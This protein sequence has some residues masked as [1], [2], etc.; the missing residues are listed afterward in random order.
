MEGCA[1]LYITFQKA[2]KESFVAVFPMLVEKRWVLV[3]ENNV[4]TFFMNSG[5][6]VGE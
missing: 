4:T 3:N 1:S 6:G 2:I 5:Y